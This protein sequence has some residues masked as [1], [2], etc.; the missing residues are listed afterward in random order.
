MCSCINCDCHFVFLSTYVVEL[1]KL[2][3]MKRMKESQVEAMSGGKEDVGGS[4]VQTSQGEHSPASPVSFPAS[5]V[6]S[7]VSPTSLSGDQVQN[8][9]HSPSPNDAPFL[10]VKTNYDF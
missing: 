3:E 6:S 2:V 4:E 1:E 7:P 8:T 10:Q 9:L 5:P